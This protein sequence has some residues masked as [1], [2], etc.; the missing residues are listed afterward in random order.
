MNKFMDHVFFMLECAGVL[1]VYNWNLEKPSTA[2]WPWKHFSQLNRN[3]LVH[4]KQW[5]NQH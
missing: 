1:L 5:F 3:K 4:R 2:L